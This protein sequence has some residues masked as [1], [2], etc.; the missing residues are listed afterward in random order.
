MGRA[1]RRR[2]EIDP[3]DPRDRLER[4]AAVLRE[5]IDI[6][7]RHGLAEGRA[8]S[9]F[10]LAMTLESL[11]RPEEARPA[12]ETAAAEFDRLGKSESAA[13]ARSRVHALDAAPA[14]RA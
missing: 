9:L 7:A 6:R 12:Y 5:A 11:A 2:T 13:I 3:A 10:H 4:S 14:R 1:L 8:L